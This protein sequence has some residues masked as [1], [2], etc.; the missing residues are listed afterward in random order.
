M[1]TQDKLDKYLDLL[2]ECTRG[3]NATRI[4]EELQE[5]CIELL[6]AY[7]ELSDRAY[8]RY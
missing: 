4:L 6:N 8:D 7:E 3:P 2:E 1:L 5:D